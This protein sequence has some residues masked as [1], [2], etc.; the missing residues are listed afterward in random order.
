[1]YFGGGYLLE[2]LFPVEVAPGTHELNSSIN[3]EA[4]NK[5]SRSH[6]SVATK[7]RARNVLTS[8]KY[9]MES[10][11]KI[12]SHGV[13]DYRNDDSAQPALKDK[14]HSKTPAYA[15]N[16]LSK[17]NQDQYGPV[18]DEEMEDLPF[19]NF[20]ISGHVLDE[21]GYPVSGIEVTAKAY[22]LF[23]ASVQFDTNVNSQKSVITGGAGE[24]AFQDLA[25]G[26]YSLSTAATD[27]YTSTSKN[28][29]SG[30]DRVKLKVVGSY[31][32]WV[33]GHITDSENNTLP[34]VGIFATGQEEP[35][36]SDEYGNYQFYL[37]VR[38]DRG[39]SIRFSA[40]GYHDRK[41]ALNLK[42]W[43]QQKQVERKVVMEATRE[44][45]S[46]TG[47]VR[48][49]N[50]EPVEGEQIY[51]KSQTNKY[52]ATTDKAGFFKLDDVVTGVNYT[53]WLIPKG[54]F[55]K[56]R[57]NSLQVPAKGISGLEVVLDPQGVGSL[58]GIMMDME[59]NLIPNFN[60]F[61]RSESSQTRL[62]VTSD[63]EGNFELANVPEGQIRFETSSLP[64]FIVA[65]IRL[66]DGEHEEVDLLIDRGDYSLAGQV[67]N[68][69]GQSLG[70][71]AITVSWVY[72]EN[73]LLYE[74]MRKTVSNEDGS[75]ELTGLGGG[76]YTVIASAA[77]YEGTRQEQDIGKAVSARDNY[78][79]ILLLALDET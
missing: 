16:G 67:K 34:D 40:D 56:Y 53:L 10:D 31:P 11:Q 55:K 2:G 76:T 23:E 6:V 52:K 28:V 38:N 19:G 61:V 48:V 32:I 78:V 45:A 13:I 24:F 29:R 22:H 14:P 59:G 26:E 65:G 12:E 71:A 27:S 17:N 36:F 57:N 44:L 51:L 9:E 33:Y 69:M 62:Q 20:A 72:R 70:G 74:S 60:L 41:L 68:D 15:N 49:N 7:S 37:T 47:N 58:S 42:D 8:S 18:I 46:V 25:D 30:Q 43:V 54:P 39:Y 75:F 4:E 1:M 50:G 5:S 3:Q 77:G 35:V 64:R 66:D 73:G 21:Q 79:E 63:S